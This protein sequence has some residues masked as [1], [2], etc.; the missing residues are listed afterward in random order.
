[1]TFWD[2]DMKERGFNPFSIRQ[3]EDSLCALTGYTKSWSFS[4]N[5][6]RL[7]PI[8]ITTHPLGG[9]KVTLP[10]VVYYT[11]FLLQYK[12]QTKRKFLQQQKLAASVYC[13]FW[14]N[15]I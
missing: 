1:M 13:P 15:K 12:T 5:H 2:Q 14:D 9:F 7:V 8:Y 11:H 3:E 4:S 6:I 10:A